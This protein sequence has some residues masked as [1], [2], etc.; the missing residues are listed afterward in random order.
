[1][2]AVMLMYL[3]RRCRQMLGVGFAAAALLTAAPGSAAEEKGAFDITPG[4]VKSGSAHGCPVTFTVAAQHFHLRSPTVDCGC[5]CRQPCH[6]LL[7]WHQ[8][9]TIKVRGASRLSTFSISSHWPSVCLI[10]SFGRYADSA[11][12]SMCRRAAREAEMKE[13]LAA[14]R[15][16]QSN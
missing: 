1:M 11:V 2:S 10:S 13:K 12:R 5:R 8:G 3:V 16:S 7:W 15:A 9:C 6:S 14:I 4:A